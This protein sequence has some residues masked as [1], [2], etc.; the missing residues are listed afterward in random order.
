MDERMNELA[1]EWT[2]IN[3]W[4]NKRKKEKIKNEYQS[5]NQSINQSIYMDLMSVEQVSRPK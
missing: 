1:H 4:K 3:E 5:I 2:K